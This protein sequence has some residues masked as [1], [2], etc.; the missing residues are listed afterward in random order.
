VTVSHDVADSVSCTESTKL[1]ETSTYS[2]PRIWVNGQYANDPNRAHWT[3]VGEPTVKSVALSAA[4]L[5][6]C[7][8]LPNTGSDAGP[9][10]AIGS[11][12]IIGGIL[13]IAA[14]RRRRVEG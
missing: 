10:L 11:L 7:Q 6:E 4:E 3:L 1:V 5:S 13:L 14:T 2:V 8:Q 12:F 9:M